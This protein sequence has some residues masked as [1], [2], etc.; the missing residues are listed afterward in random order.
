MARQTE[1]LL[2]HAVK[3]ISSRLSPL[4][5]EHVVPPQS[6]DERWRT[7]LAFWAL[8]FRSEPS[9]SPSG[10]SGQQRFWLFQ[11]RIS[12]GESLSRLHMPLRKLTALPQSHSFL[13]STAPALSLTSARLHL[14]SSLNPPRG[15]CSR[16]AR[17]MSV[18]EMLGQL[19]GCSTSPFPSESYSLHLSG[20]KKLWIC[21]LARQMW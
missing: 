14:G 15:D 3:P 19:N 4:P 9:L 18:I 11:R 8:P 5:T 7:S 12:C 10:L 17:L 13:C 2:K 20:R 16:R 6:C 1:V 21:R